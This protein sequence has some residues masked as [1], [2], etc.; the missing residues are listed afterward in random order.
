MYLYRVILG[1]CYS[2]LSKE[3][4]KDIMQWPDIPFCTMADEEKQTERICMSESIEGCLT[5]IGW[6][7]LERAFQEYFEDNGEYLKVTILIFDTENLD[8]KY[9]ISPEELDEKGYVPDAYITKEWWYLLPAKPDFLE[10]KH[11]YDYN[12]D[13]FDFVIPKELRNKKLTHEEYEDLI[14][15]NAKFHVIQD[16]VW[17]NNS[18]IA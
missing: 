8:N 11:L 5:S 6:N 10:I 2:H 1:E 7:R 9:L 4:I 14:E 12:C 17:K 16:L 3:D 15:D 18:K 13:N